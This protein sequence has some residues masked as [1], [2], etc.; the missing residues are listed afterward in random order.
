M[1]RT[2]LAHRL[3][4]YRG[5]APDG[6]V[7]AVASVAGAP[8][9]LPASPG[10]TS[11]A[12]APAPVFRLPAA[13]AACELAAIDTSC[14]EGEGTSDNDEIASDDE[15]AFH[16]ASAE[17]PA[18]EVHD[19]VREE[20]PGMPADPPVPVPHAASV[21]HAH[22]IT[23]AEAGNEVE[24]CDDQAEVARVAAEVRFLEGVLREYQAVRVC[25]VTATA[26]GDVRAAAEAE[27]ARVMLL[28]A[29][30]DAVK[31]VKELRAQ[32]LAIEAA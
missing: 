15:D 9:A 6:G 13:A 1:Q 2:R 22:A 27:A 4:A 5:A 16:D 10:P 3:Q 14:S 28:P 7:D 12:L 30:R 32:C 17:A 24:A 29:A 18:E 26:G 11:L 25:A 19:D 21:H 8:L 23:P 20:A 31:R